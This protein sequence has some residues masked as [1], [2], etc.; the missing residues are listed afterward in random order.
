MPAIANTNIVEATFFGTLQ[1]QTVL[2]VFHY[3]Y[4][5][6]GIVAA[7]YA[8]NLAALGLGIKA[9][10]W[11]H[12][13]NGFKNFVSNEY[14]LLKIRTQL[15]APVRGYYVDTAVN[16][17]GGVA[18]PSMPVNDAITLSLT[19]DRAI[20]GG[21][22]SKRFAGLPT[23][24]HLQGKWTV[25]AQGN[26]ASVG[27][28]ILL[29]QNGIGVLDVFFPIVWSKKRSADRSTVLS[30]TVRPEVRTQHRRTVGLGI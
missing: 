20:Q 22:G 25:A 2:N 12:A 5:G 10:I 17:A 4:S 9:S 23:V 6:P 14:A 26:W 18:S 19:T 8:A 16:E 28:Q 24:G 29:S 11:G 27:T 3:Q 15:V 13:V 7:D 1:N 30:V 21:T